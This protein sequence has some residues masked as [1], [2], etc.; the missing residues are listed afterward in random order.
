MAR[1]TGP[2]CKLCRREG[3]KLFLKGAR[4]LSDKC[5]VTRRNQPPG[6]KHLRT[7]RGHSEYGRH[8]R[9]KQKV[10]RIY[11]ILETQFRRYYEEA[12]RVRGVTG[13]TLL[14][15]LESRLD[16]VIYTAGFSASRAEARQ[17]IRQNKVTVN[18]KPVNIPSYQVKPNDVLKFVAVE[19]AP[20]PEDEMP[21]WLLWDKS[22]KGIKMNS[23]PTRDDIHHEINEQLIVEY[24]SR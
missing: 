7:R 22:E 18:G 5:A 14:I 2:K 8:L 16:S 3:Q 24:Y 9:E 19:A 10:K 11:G 13:Q 23:L 6:P 1:Y 21:A 12:A 4:C 20:R 17:K 15:I